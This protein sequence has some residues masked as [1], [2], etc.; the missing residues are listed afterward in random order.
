MGKSS[1]VEWKPVSEDL[2]ERLQILADQVAD[3]DLADEADLFQTNPKTRRD[4]LSTSLMKTFR[5]SGSKE[6]FTLL[7]ELNYHDFQRRIYHHL[8]RVYNPVDASDVLQ[9][10]FFNVYRYPFNFKP[11]SASA[12]RNWTHTIIRNT[13]LKYSRKAQRNRTLPFDTPNRYSFGD[14]EDFMVQEPE[15]TQAVNPL[16]YTENLEEEEA[17]GRAWYLYL[18]LYLE[19]F[20]SLS[21]REKRVLHLTEVEGLPYREIA[22]LVGGRPANMK[23]IVFRARQRIFQRMKARFQLFEGNLRRFR[24]D[25]WQETTPEPL[26]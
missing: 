3:Q 14:Q 23:M 20:R 5:D 7:Y 18:Q 2:A 6:A 12:F 13:V 19:A 21:P 11:N 4:A 26:N 16:A 1:S 9:E 22:P 10:V 15:D 17:V 25:R 8:R 24:R